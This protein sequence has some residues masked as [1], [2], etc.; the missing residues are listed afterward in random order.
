[1]SQKVI[2]LTDGL[3]FSVADV[4][5]CDILIILSSEISLNEAGLC[6]YK[7]LVIKL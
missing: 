1:M 2:K 5:V 6:G 4:L 7:F 3:K